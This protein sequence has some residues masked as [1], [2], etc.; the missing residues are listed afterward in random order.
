[1]GEY[2]REMVGHKRRGNEGENVKC[3]LYLYMKIKE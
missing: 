1:V 2:Q 3:I